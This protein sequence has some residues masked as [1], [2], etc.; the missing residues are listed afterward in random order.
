ML[1]SSYMFPTDETCIQRTLSHFKKYKQP[2]KSN[3]CLYYSYP[4]KYTVKY[5][6]QIKGAKA[7]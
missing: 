6:K 1:S 2:Q 7:V 4:E 3:N 5:I